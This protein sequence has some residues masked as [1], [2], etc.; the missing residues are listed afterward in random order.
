MTPSLAFL[1]IKTGDLRAQH[2]L[3]EEISMLSIHHIAASAAGEVWFGGQWQGGL[4]SSPELIG[5]ASAD[6]PITIF[7]PAEPMG[8]ALKGYI[9][10]VALS[11]DGRVLAASAPRAGRVVYLD[12][13]TGAVRAETPIA[14][15]CGIA[16]LGED[17]FALSSGLGAWRV[18]RPG[19]APLSVATVDG[20]A[21]D[22]HLRLIR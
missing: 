15:G 13:E 17:L 14:D 1:D 21:F 6:K 8:T 22:N 11:R 7:E 10:S 19:E 4:E 5:R 2:M 12:T 20:T 16:P 3:P 9:G 18:E